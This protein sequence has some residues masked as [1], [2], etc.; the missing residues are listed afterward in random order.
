MQ[1]TTVGVVVTASPQAA[2]RRILPPNPSCLSIVYRGNIKH[3]IGLVA[4]EEKLSKTK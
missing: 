2:K 4:T 1:V 3:T